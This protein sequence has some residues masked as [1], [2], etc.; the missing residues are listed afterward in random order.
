M[1]GV[2]SAKAASLRSEIDRRPGRELAHDYARRLGCGAS[3]DVP[4]S[5]EQKDPSPD[6]SVRR[7]PLQPRDKIVLQ[8]LDNRCLVL[9]DPAPL[10]G[11]LL[12]ESTRERVVAEG[13]ETLVLLLRSGR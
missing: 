4:P 1:R 8:M 5:A 7:G 3:T 6:L 12:G 2:S 10:A 11:G 13:D 9:Q